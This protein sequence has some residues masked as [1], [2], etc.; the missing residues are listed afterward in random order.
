MQCMH[1]APFLGFCVTDQ[2]VLIQLPP[3][4]HLQYGFHISNSLP[5]TTLTQGANNPRE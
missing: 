5:E 4:N 1:C 2:P 3:V